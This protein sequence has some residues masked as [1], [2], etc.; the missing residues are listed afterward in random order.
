MCVSV[1]V[2]GLAYRH[3]ME[4]QLAVYFELVG[5]CHPATRVQNN[6]IELRVR[7]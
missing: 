1:C 6:V 5:G 4:R 3:A 7:E 2:C